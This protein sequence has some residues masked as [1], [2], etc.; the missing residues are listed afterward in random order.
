MRT[1]LAGK[2][3]FEAR[4]RRAY[5]LGLPMN[6]NRHEQQRWPMWARCAWA[7]GWLFQQPS[8]QLTESIVSS[9]EEEAERTGTTLRATVDRFL[10]STKGEST[11]G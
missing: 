8:R 2:A 7:R 9:F 10:A 11:N 5:S 4:G 6:H 3:W 1:P